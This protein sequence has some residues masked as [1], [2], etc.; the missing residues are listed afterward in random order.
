MLTIGKDLLAAQVLLL[1]GPE[2]VSVLFVLLGHGGLADLHVALVHNGRCL[3]G[4]EAL[5]VVW[6]DTVRCQHG[7][8]SGRVLS[9][10]VVLI[11]ILNIGASLQQF[12]GALGSV[13]VTLLFRELCVGVLNRFLHGDALS[14]V[15]V[16]LLL[17]QSIEV[18][19]LLIVSLLCESLL[20]LEGLT[21]SDL[22][23]NPIFLL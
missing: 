16:L 14:R 20:L 5:E 22:L 23:I 7:L 10:E 3:L 15:L 2:T 19:S 17:K 12:I 13:S 11:C 4:I 1:L 9:H 8:L 6:L 21:L 18:Q